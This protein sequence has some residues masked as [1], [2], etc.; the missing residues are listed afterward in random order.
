MDRH[1][2]RKSPSLS[3]LSPMPLAWS[4]LAMEPRA[5]VE[6]TVVLDAELRYDGRARGGGPRSISLA[7]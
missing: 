3:S 5:L 2:V 7:T 4:L 1:G 6:V